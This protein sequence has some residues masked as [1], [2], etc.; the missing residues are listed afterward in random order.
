[1]LQ[2]DRGQCSSVRSRSCVPHKDA[3]LPALQVFMRPLLSPQYCQKLCLAECD[4]NCVLPVTAISET[5]CTPKLLLDDS[6]DGKGD[7]I[8][9]PSMDE[10]AGDKAYR[11]PESFPCG[12]ICR[13]LKAAGTRI[14]PGEIGTN[15]GLRKLEFPFFYAFFLFFFFL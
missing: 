2:D 13:Q 11:P 15:M 14:K 10:T 8:A 5:K 12:V 7:G 6:M 3:D 9:V 4:R 1:M